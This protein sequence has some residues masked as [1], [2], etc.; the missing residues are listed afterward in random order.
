M[1]WRGLPNPRFLDMKIEFELSEHQL[2]ELAGA[3]AEELVARKAVA[4]RREEPYTAAEAA[5]ALKV[6]VP[7]ISRM[8][9]AGKLSRIEAMGRILIPACQ[10]D[11][12]LEVGGNG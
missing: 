7:T 4:S 2:K 8:V 12:M 10:I 9:A 11:S 3:V 5:E 6:S 1:R